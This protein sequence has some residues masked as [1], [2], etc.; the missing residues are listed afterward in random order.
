[1]RILV[2][3]TSFIG[4]VILATSLLESL[5]SE[6][7]N[8]QLDIIVRKGNEGLF[9]G[10]PFLQNVFVWDK[11]N[12]KLTNLF[13]LISRVRKAEYEIVVN[14][15]RFASSGLIAALSGARVKVGFKKN[16]LS[17]FYTDLADHAF[18]GRHEIERNHQLIA[19]LVKTKHPK[20]PK[21]YP[22]QQD[23]RVVSQ[24][25]KTPY[26]CIAPTS[27]W[28]TKQWPKDKW[29]EL[30]NQIPAGEIIYLLGAPGDHSACQEIEQKIKREN[31]EILAGKLTLLQ[32]AALMQ[33]AIMNYVNDSAPMHLAS[34]VNAPTTAIFCSTIPKFGFG[35]LSS[36]SKVVETSE[37]LSCRPCGIHG[38]GICPEH[39]FKCTEISIESVLR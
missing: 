4:D 6:Y 21:L 16:P 26:R 11:T 37:T 2:I 17:M 38:H 9:S 13:K 36:V 31:V 27:V 33:G 18:D 8:A 3:Q 7:P 14:A 24:Y 15:H 32:S 1:M 19:K 35:P 39:H 10:H 29:V 34:S 30:C 28:H 5:R 12:A 23:L 22:T 25:M 20:K